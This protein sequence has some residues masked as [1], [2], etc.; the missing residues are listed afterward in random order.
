[1]HEALRVGRVVLEVGVRRWLLPRELVRLSRSAQLRLAADLEPTGTRALLR[2][3]LE[4][5][6]PPLSSAAAALVCVAGADAGTVFLLA[7]AG[8]ELGRSPTCAVQLADGAVSRLHLRLLHDRGGTH[9]VRDLGSRNRTR[10]NGRW[11]RSS[12]L[13]SDGD[14]LGVGRSLLHYRS[15]SPEPRSSSDPEQGRR[16]DAVSASETAPPAPPAA[17]SDAGA[18][19]RSS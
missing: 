8:L 5:G 10:C 13:L 4:P 14:V 9:R 19:R 11:L 16:S 1:M 7:G 3:L 15:E 2:S 12:L 6:G 18:G 17:P